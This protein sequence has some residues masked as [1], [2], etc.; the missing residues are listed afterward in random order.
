MSKF[1]KIILIMLLVIGLIGG[2]YLAYNWY[3]NRDVAPVNNDTETNQPVDINN[4]DQLGNIILQ[5]LA[6]EDKV[7]DSGSFSSDGGGIPLTDSEKVIADKAVLQQTAR[8]FTEIFGSYSS[9]NNFQNLK[10]LKSLMTTT[11]WAK[12]EKDLANITSNT[13]YSVWSQAMNATIDQY[14]ASAGTVTVLCKRGE[15]KSKT[16]K[17]NIF[18]QSAQVNLVKVNGTWLVDKVV[19][20]E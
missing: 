10:D 16:E 8:Y 4:T 14:S 7:I 13:T 18:Y 15:R 3:I 9:D 17:E 1:L 5:D 6:T 11:Y 19:W 20:L 2:G 12:W